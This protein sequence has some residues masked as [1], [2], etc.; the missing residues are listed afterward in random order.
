MAEENKNKIEGDRIE[1]AQDGQE[2]NG[3][4]IKKPETD[5]SNGNKDRLDRLKEIMERNKQQ[6]A[7]MKNQDKGPEILVN[8]AEESSGGQAKDDDDDD[9]EEKDEDGDGDDSKEKKQQIAFHAEDISKL[10]NADHQVEKLVELAEQ[11]DPYVAVKVAKKMD[12]NYVID[13]MHDEL[14]EDKVRKVLI[15]KGLLKNE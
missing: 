5:F 2:A 15:E 10:E 14:V 13:R 8:K 6:I 3:G 1:G 12:D 9:E 11:K 4:E 7:G